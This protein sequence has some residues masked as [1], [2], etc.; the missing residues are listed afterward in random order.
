[1]RPY[2]LAGGDAAPFL[3][4]EIY[5]ALRYEPSFDALPTKEAHAKSH[6]DVSR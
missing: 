4:R 6:P 3:T 1:M 5:E 2:A